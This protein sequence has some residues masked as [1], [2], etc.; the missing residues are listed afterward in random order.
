MEITDTAAATLLILASAVLHAVWNAVLKS[1]TD[2]TAMIGILNLAA[3]GVS[4]PLLML[5]PA[6]SGMDWWWIAVSVV[7]HLAYQ[8]SLARMMATADYS[9]VYPLSRGLGPLVVV[10]V[11]LGF[12]GEQLNGVETLA[13]VVLITGAVLAGLAGAQKLQLPPASALFWAGL[14][15][16]LIGSYTLVDGSAVKTMSP[17]T[18]IFWS[19]ILIMPP[20]ML[21]LFQTNGPALAGRLE[22]SWLRGLL[23]TVIAYTGY[24]MALFA[25][26][27]GN[28]AEIAALRETSIFFAALIGAFWLRES[29][30]QLRLLG[31]TLIAIG[32]IALK[33]F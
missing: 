28:L 24:T 25:F 2:R 27:L 26:R 22:A 33:L 17:L 20:M 1:S 4:L 16:L 8:L 31:I 32:A 6:P 9:L 13:I 30:T 29:P 21:F 15:G 7:I 12:L 11:S 14:V 10:L 23:M 18:F 19:N 3:A 5:V